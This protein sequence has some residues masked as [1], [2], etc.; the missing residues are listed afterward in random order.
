MFQFLEEP[1]QFAKIKVIGLG[2]GGSNAVNRMISARLE[3]VEFMVANTDVQALRVSHAPVKLQ[4]GSKLTN[5]L[6]SGGNPEIGRQAALEDTDKILNL[7]EGADMVFITAGLGGGTGT[8]AAPVVASLAKELGALTVAVVTKPFL[9]EGSRRSLQAGEGFQE[10]KRCVDTL[11]A[12]PNQRLLNVV[13]KAT[14]MIEAFKICDDVLRQA[15]KG[16]SDLVTVPGL[17][18]LDFADVRSIMHDMGMALMGIGIAKGERR[19]EEAAERA[20]RSP[21]L[22]DATIDGAK[23]VIINITGGTDLALH[24]VNEAA[25]RIHEAADPEANII[26]GAVIDEN[27]VDE[28][29]V[30]VIATGFRV[31]RDLAKELSSVRRGAGTSPY[32]NQG[33][34]DRGAYLRRRQSTSGQTRLNNAGV[35]PLEDEDLEVPTFLRRQAD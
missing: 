25:T 1:E 8:G 22:E 18:N 26:F 23:G 32:A 33:A 13:E 24:E 5:G 15:V 30:T 35:P 27:L 12:I 21:L 17:I 6:G 28:V 10:L 16:I 3:G 19:A 31:E 29:R 7:L 9:F 34:Q 11:I 2:G 20:I 14:T 4:I